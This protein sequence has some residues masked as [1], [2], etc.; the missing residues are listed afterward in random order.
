MR[1]RSR[2]HTWSFAALLPLMAFFC[3]SSPA[4]A[5]G[6]D[7][8][9][10]IGPE[11]AKQNRMSWKGVCRHKA[12]FILSVMAEDHVCR[13]AYGT[14]LN[15]GR[16]HVETMCQIEGLWRWMDVESLVVKP[17]VPPSPNFRI[18]RWYTSWEYLLRLRTR[19]FAEETPLMHQ[20]PKTWGI[21]SAA[22]RR[23][24]RRN[25]ETDALECRELEGE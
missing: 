24:D 1:T 22:I 25:A 12:A 20:L 2:L 11:Y 17:T 8:Y 10:D 3:L 21:D 9:W 13:V 15:S 23:R 14:N 6:D 5:A 7:L 19:F 18:E 4:L 16:K